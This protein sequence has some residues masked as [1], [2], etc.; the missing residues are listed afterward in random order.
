MNSSFKSTFFSWR[1]WTETNVFIQDCLNKAAVAFHPSPWWRVGGS[2][3]GWTATAAFFSYRGNRAISKWR[4][5]HW[6]REERSF[7]N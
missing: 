6:G 5:F 4:W 2:R 3:R 1:G 7:W